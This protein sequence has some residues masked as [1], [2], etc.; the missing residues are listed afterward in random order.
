MV[1]CL[2]DLTA[3]RMDEQSVATTVA[4]SVGSTVDELVGTRDDA[5]VAQKAAQLAVG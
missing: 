1:V 4:D 2:V 5:M 3:A